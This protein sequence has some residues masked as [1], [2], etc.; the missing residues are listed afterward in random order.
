MGL[1]WFFSGRRTCP[2]LH[3]NMT[4]RGRLT[5]RALAV[6]G[7]VLATVGLST[8]SATADPAPATPV[9][10][11][12]TAGDGRIDVAWLADAAAAD[13][14][15][16]TA[17]PGGASCASTTSGCSIT[18]LTDGV[19][20]SVTLEAIVGEASSPPSASSGP[21]TPVDLTAPAL[22]SEAIS[23]TT[24]PLGG[25]PVT[26][27]ARIADATSGVDETAPSVWL[28]DQNGDAVAQAPLT[29]VSGDAADGEYSGT[30]TVPAG[31]EK[32]LWQAEIAGV[33]DRAGNGRDSVRLDQWIETGV[34][35]PPTNVTAVVEGRV[36][37]VTWS[38]SPTGNGQ[39][40]TGYSV[41]A[42]DVAQRAV[43]VNVGPESTSAD[44]LAGD[45]T[46]TTLFIY[47]TASTVTSSSPGAG[48]P[49]SVTLRP[50]PPDAPVAQATAGDGQVLVTWAAPPHTNGAPISQYTVLL[51]PGGQSCTRATVGSC[52]FSVVNGTTYTAVVTASNTAG[53]SAPSSVGNLDPH[54][55]PPAPADVTLSA[56]DSRTAR[57]TWADSPTDPGAL[58]GF[59]VEY[60]PDGGPYQSISLPATQRSFT[61][62]SSTD[63]ASLIPNRP[64]TFRITATGPAL[65]SASIAAPQHPT[66]PDLRRR[67]NTMHRPTVTSRDHSTATVRWTRATA[68]GGTAITGYLVRIWNGTTLIRATLLRAIA[69]HDC[70]I[71]LPF[72]KRYRARVYAINQAG[73]SPASPA[74]SFHLGHG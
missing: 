8:P 29:L 17:S 21:V 48:A 36:I 66:F 33:K 30:L 5:G 51:E 4:R 63:H 37:H 59:D 68:P 41:V 13:E 15:V 42:S 67:P 58:T 71:D 23:P 6:I 50:A 72:G 24:L 28:V 69:R 35:A 3:C 11:T 22:D 61:V 73:M 18:G 44:L 54:A 31:G 20:Y 14:V 65:H 25:G 57:L 52:A 38:P 2:Y 10:N 12:V 27:S 53:N 32:A 46:S 55:S 60:G 56:R 70:E 45:L 1:A 47:A 9:F 74:S 26:V 43:I 62:T 19:A 64:Y 34:P 16:A 40:I 39:P 7:A 49:G